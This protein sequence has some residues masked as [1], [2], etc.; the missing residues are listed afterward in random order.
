MQL[1]INFTDDSNKYIGE[2]GK[3]DFELWR[4]DFKNLK[5]VSKF[6]VGDYDAIDD[7]PTENGIVFVSGIVGQVPNARMKASMVIKSIISEFFSIPMLVKIEPFDMVSV[8]DNIELDN[9]LIEI[10]YNKANKLSD[11]LENK[12]SFDYITDR[13]RK[14]QL[15]YVLWLNFT[16][17]TVKINYSYNKEGRG[18]ANTLLYRQFVA[19]IDEQYDNSISA[20][21]LN[22]LT[23][24][25]NSLSESD[26]A[27]Y[28]ELLSDVLPKQEI[29]PKSWSGF[30]KKTYTKQEDN[31]NTKKSKRKKKNKK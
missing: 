10:D 25:L 12:K 21:N 18:G 5:Y 29:I 27:T 1:G 9:D 30:R 31:S 15:R 19:F 6:T 22:H 16:D 13:L 23:A 20:K 7:T 26:L 8:V 14:E 3:L 2:N 28:T 11:L 17:G 4:E 24:Q